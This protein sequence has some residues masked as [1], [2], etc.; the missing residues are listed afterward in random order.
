MD[1]RSGGRKKEMPEILL[2]PRGE[3][4]CVLRPTVM[5]CTTLGSSNSVNAGMQTGSE[6]RGRPSEVESHKN[7]RDPFFCF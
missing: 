5:Q 6:G 4:F 7:D 3:R 1:A 2:S